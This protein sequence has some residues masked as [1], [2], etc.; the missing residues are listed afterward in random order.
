[1]YSNPNEE[2][3]AT[4]HI[5]ETSNRRFRDDEFLISRELTRGRRSIW[6]K[7]K[8]TPV[9]R[10]LYPGFPLGERAWSE[11]RY[12]AYCFVMPK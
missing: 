9:E 12:T 7:V 5:V 8:F 11:I 6:L 1:M 2:L 10:P 4:Q 3:G